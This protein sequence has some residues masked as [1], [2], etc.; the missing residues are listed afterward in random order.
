MLGIVAAF[1]LGLGLGLLLFIVYACL[2]V[3]KRADG[4]KD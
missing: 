1:C 2:V 3:A 4:E